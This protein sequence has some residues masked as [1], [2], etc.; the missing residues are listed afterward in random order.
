[1]PDNATASR[2]DARGPLVFD[3]RPLQRRPGE[4]R[5]IQR[6]V[7][8]PPGLGL[9]LVGVPDGSPIEL[10][11]RLESVVEG[12]YASGTVY[13]ALA[14]ECARCLDPLTSDVE[15]EFEE[16]FYY[17]EGD[18]GEDDATLDGDLLDLGP[19]LRDAI[20]LELPLSP[21]CRDDCPGLCSQC[22]ARLADAGPEHRHETSDPRWAALAGLYDEMT[23]REEN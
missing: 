10:D 2:N 4:M 21:V 19:V 22:G 14:G 6:S 16:L 23:R 3:T 15:A 13:A 17:P 9:P 5:E 1:M 12:V 11:L 20:V 8:A 18:I 7:P